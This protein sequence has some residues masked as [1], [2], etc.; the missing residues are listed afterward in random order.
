MSG[1][2]KLVPNDSR[3]KYA[4]TQV[5]GKTY[6]YMLGEPTGSQFKGLI[7]LVHGFPDLG[8]GWRCQIPFLM[9]LGYRV[10]VPDMLGFGGTDDP[11]DIELYAQK[12]LAAD[13]NDLARHFVGPDGQIILGGH[14]WGGALVWRICLWHP[15]L[16]RAVFSVCTPYFPPS[17]R[18]ASLEDIVASGKAKNFSYQLHFKGLEIEEHCQG[19]EK[20][21][22]FL[23]S[24]YGGRT[25]EGEVAFDAGKGVF[26]DK[27]PRLERS[28]LVSKEE[29]D[30]YVQQY[31][32]RGENGERQLRGPLNWYRMRE[33]NFRDE[34]PLA[35]AGVRLEMPALYIAASRDTA[36]PPAMSGGMEA[37]IKQLSRAEVNATHW[38]LTQKPQDVNDIIG[39]WLKGLDKRPGQK[40]SL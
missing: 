30:Y 37:H 29:L 4:S 32:R 19:E 36:L 38:A 15:E 20:V 24:L 1:V 23:N 16:I 25:P 28:R 5:R 12:S 9:S 17:K 31:M 33:A 3:V 35:K 22:Q 2:S 27:L 10:L 34:E 26:F 13:M 21:R 39:S 14:D 18:Y 40:S 8:F 7:L 6:S 11:K